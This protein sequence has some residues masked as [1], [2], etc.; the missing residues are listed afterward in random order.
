MLGNLSTKNCGLNAKF[1]NFK[2][3]DNPSDDGHGDIE[4]G[5]NHIHHKMKILS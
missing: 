5:N 4:D 3:K 2:V 1:E